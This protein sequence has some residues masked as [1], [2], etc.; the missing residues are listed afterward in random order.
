MIDHIHP[1]ISTTL[2]KITD[3][4][5]AKPQPSIDDLR[6]FVLVAKVGSFARVAEQRQA[7]PSSISTAISRLEAQLGARLF[8]RTTRTVVLTH[9]GSE[10]LGRSE[11]MLDEFDEITGLF[12]QSASQLV[13]RLRVDIPLGM[14]SGIVMDMLPQ[15]MARHPGLQME[16]MSTDRRVDV[17]ADGVDCVVRGGPVIDELL[18]CRPLGALPLIN[19]ASPGYLA[20]HGTPASLDD[21]GGHYLVNYAP[22]PADQPAGFAYLDGGQERVLPMA[23]RITVNNSAAYG[24]ACRAGF[25][26]AQVPLIGHAAELAAGLLVQVLPQTTPGPMP[27]NQLY[28]HHRNVPQRVRLFG[29]WL[30]DIVTNAMGGSHV[31]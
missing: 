18:A 26:I 28:P 19:V 29:D 27:L 8:H 5:M 16:V 9:E 30:A 13:G 7:A 4:S 6:I 24:A 10:L 2:I 11:R 14:A 31:A 15:F 12:R 23:H 22:N 1:R 25:G 20:I 3:E 17:V 21:L